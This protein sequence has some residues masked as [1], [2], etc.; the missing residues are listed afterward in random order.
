[1]PKIVIGTDILSDFKKGIKK[2][3]ITTN[4]LGGY[5][6][7]TVN[8]CNTRRY[9]GLLVTSGK[10]GHGRNVLLSKLEETIKVGHKY[11]YLGTNQYQENYLHPRGYT[12][13][14]KFEQTPFPRF[15]YTIDDLVI[16]KEIFMPRGKRT[17]VIRYNLFGGKRDF[18][19]FLHPLTEFVN[20]HEIQRENREFNTWTEFKDG[21]LRMKPYENMPEL[22]LY[23]PGMEYKDLKNWYKNFVLEI[24]KE[25]GLNYTGDLFNPG[26]FS[27]PDVS[28]MSFDVIATCE[29]EIPDNVDELYREARE[30]VDRLFEIANAAPDDPDENSLI[31]AADLH[32][33]KTPGGNK[34]QRSTIVAGYHWFGDW[35]RDT[36]ISLPGITLCTGRFEEAREILHSFALQ[37][38]EGIIPNRFSDIGE[39]AIYNTVDASLW[40]VNAVNEYAK[41]SGDYDFIRGEVFETCQS[42]MKNYEKG[43]LFGIGMDEDC[44]IKAGE[45]GYQLTWMDAKV[46]EWVVTP[47]M[48]KPVEINALWYNALCIMANLSEKFEKKDEASYYNELAKKV[49]KSF[50]EKFWNEREKY[51]YDVITDDDKDADFRC[52]QVFAVSLP[53]PVLDADKQ[54]DVV[55]SVYEKLYT[56]FGLRSLSP[57][58]PNYKGIYRGNIRERDGAYHQ[59][60][61]WGWL[62]GPFIEA[63]LKVH[64]YSDEA[65][66]QA[67]TLM[68][69][70]MGELTKGGMNTLS[71]LVDGDEPFTSRG[72][73]SQAWS[74]GEALRLKKIINERKK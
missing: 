58:N 19:F 18:S 72:C 52:N 33:V 73:I 11:Y 5:A 25:R 29:E 61:A 50:N 70:W 68:D 35:G 3:W 53:Y 54:E 64:N 49:K 37:C 55:S 71:E 2:E 8:G 28:T 26:Y 43:T 47:R 40:Y 65:V 46:G 32:I 15:I 16:T 10:D 27:S 69:L 41:Y 48:G 63:Y 38:K 62:M 7:S 24:E 74:I 4:G 20:F 42:I 34:D 66:V 13:L 6:S 51:L 59:G 9:H 14:R 21:I 56:P 45:E 30:N 44:L 17:T 12:H 31:L 57:D 22:K 1:M 60:I 23:M 67:D 36:F 39:E